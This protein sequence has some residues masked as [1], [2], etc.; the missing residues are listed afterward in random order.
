MWTP[1]TGKRSSKKRPVIVSKPGTT[2]DCGIATALYSIVPPRWP[3]V[4]SLLVIAVVLVV[5]GGPHAAGINGDRVIGV[6]VSV[7][8]VG[9]GDGVGVSVG[10]SVGNGPP[11]GVSVG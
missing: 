11:T 7:G 9:V 1:G 6:G 5:P 2:G 4:P 10:V 8:P 3:T